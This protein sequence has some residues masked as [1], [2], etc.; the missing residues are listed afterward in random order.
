MIPER[1]TI[2]CSAT[3]NGEYLDIKKIREWHLARG[4]SDIG[5]H[6]VINPSGQVDRGRSLTTQGAGVSGANRNNVHI[7]MVGSDKF[8]MAQFVS[9]RYHLEGLDQIYDI[10]PKDIYCHYEYASAIKQGK[11]CPNMRSSNIALWY[12]TQSIEPI[13]PYIFKKR[14]Y[15]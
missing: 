12:A 8:T 4:W 3:K 7:C 2:H 6:L 5:Y 15:D 13:R 11:S 10:G 9:L 14:C 1:V